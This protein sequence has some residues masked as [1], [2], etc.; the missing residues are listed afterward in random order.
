MEK[1]YK[2]KNYTLERTK[3]NNFRGGLGTTG[4]VCT[5]KSLTF[6]SCGDEIVARYED[7]DSAL[8]DDNNQLVKSWRTITKQL[9]IA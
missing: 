6:E 7:Q 4:Q 3:Y 9:N 5:E 1:I 8:Y 2:F